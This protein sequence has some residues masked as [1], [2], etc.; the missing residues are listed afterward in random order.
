MDG[1]LCS[2]LTKRSIDGSQCQREE[3][4]EMVILVIWA[5]QCFGFYE[6]NN[7]SCL[8]RRRVGVQVGIYFCSVDTLDEVNDNH[9]VMNLISFVLDGID[10]EKIVWWAGE[11]LN[12]R[13]Y[14]KCTVWTLPVLN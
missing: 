9:S 10:G 6:I 2:A 12:M 14:A 8:W 1:K 4:V 3:Y 11:L 5:T 7:Y 13:A